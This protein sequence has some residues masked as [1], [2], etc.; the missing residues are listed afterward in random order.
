MKKTCNGCKAL[1]KN[2][3][4]LGCICQLHHPIQET[5]SYFGVPTEYKPLEECE[6]PKTFA[7]L[8]KYPIIGN[9]RR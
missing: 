2:I 7:E 1:V 4:G 5:N 3:N 8:S 6:K 9:T